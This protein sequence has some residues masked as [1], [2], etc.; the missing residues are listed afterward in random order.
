MRFMTIEF[1]TL[2]DG[3]ATTRGIVSVDDDLEMVVDGR[4]EFDVISKIAKR[5]V[6][7]EI[8]RV[9][10][11]HD[12]AVVEDHIARMKAAQKESE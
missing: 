3:Y 7:R 1:E 6:E 9:V 12:P 11:G 8:N 5:F 2:D 4:G 10:C